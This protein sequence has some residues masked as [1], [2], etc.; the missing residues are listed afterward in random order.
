MSV[1]SQL[2]SGSIEK[3]YNQPGQTLTSMNESEASEAY[4]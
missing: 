2:W 4:Q 1:Y 3:A